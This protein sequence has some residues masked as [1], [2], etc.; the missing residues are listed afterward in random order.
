MEVDV[1]CQGFG[2]SSLLV[3]THPGCPGLALGL[4]A[5]RG[6]PGDAEGHG[7]CPPRHSISPEGA[8]HGSPKCP[9]PPFCFRKSSLSGSSSRQAP[10]WKDAEPLWSLGLSPRS[11]EFPLLLPR[12][13]PTAGC[14]TGTWAGPGGAEAGAVPWH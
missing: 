4:C 13:V 11:Q 7:V 10:I 14:R 8:P 9:R 2:P 5:R 6:Q 1:Q 3:P 12:N